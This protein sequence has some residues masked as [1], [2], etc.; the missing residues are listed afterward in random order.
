MYLYKYI[1]KQGHQGNLAYFLLFQVYN[2]LTKVLN[3]CLNIE[4]YLC[5]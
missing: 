3:T 2:C 4:Y 1:G 5:N